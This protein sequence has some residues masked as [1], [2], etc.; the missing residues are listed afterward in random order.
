MLVIGI[1]VGLVA[2]SAVWH[3]VAAD[4]GVAETVVLSPLILLLV[5]LALVVAIVASLY[6]SRRARRAPVAAVLRVE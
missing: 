4:L 3:A 2:G 1:P 5:P 6:P